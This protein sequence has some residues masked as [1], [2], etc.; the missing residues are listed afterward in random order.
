MSEFRSIDELIGAKRARFA[1]DETTFEWR[2]FATRAKRSANYAC[3]LCRKGGPHVC[4]VV[5]HPFYE[6]GRRKWE[7]EFKDV[8]VL[9]QPCHELM[10]ERLQEFRRHVF[11]R[12]TPQ[13]MR[14]LNGAL[15]VGL[16]HYDASVLA[17]AVA[18]LVSSPG[19]VKRFADDWRETE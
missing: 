16:E 8:Q 15:S 1:Q 13:S 14:V 2:E 4:L 3:Q 10:H 7:Y 11:A 9:C 18:A 17:R 6:L 12:L 5:H 19:A